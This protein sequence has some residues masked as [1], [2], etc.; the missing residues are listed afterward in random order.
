[1]P[2]KKPVSRPRFMVLLLV[3]GTLAVYLPAARHEFT[4]YDDSVYVS[5]NPVV[6]SGLTWT[7]IKWAFTTWHGANWH[8]LTWLSHMIDCQ[9]FG[10]NA[11]MHHEINVLFHTANVVLLFHLLR[12]W[13]RALWPSAVAAALFAWHPL[14]V[15]SVAWISERKDVLSTFFALLSLLAYTRFADEFKVQGP[16]S[17]L[18]YALAL[19]MFALGLMAKPTVVTL[20]FV[21]LLLDYWPLQR[22]EDRRFGSGVPGLVLEKIPFFALSGGSCVITFLA[23]HHGGAVATL[24]KVPLHYRLENVPVAYLG[25]LQ[26]LFWPSALAIPYPMLYLPMLRVAAA[27]AVLIL[28][29]MAFWWMRKRGPYWMVGW[30]WF[31]GTLVPVIGLLQVGSAAMADR[32]TYFPSI[33][34]FLALALG[35][36]AGVKGLHWPR[37]VVGWVAGAALA[38]CL[39]LTSFQLSYWENDISLFSHAVAVTKDNGVAHVNLGYALEKEGRKTE[40]TVEYLFAIKLE[41][42]MVEPHNDL[43]HLLDETGHPTEAMAEYREA[44]RIKPGY[45]ASHNNYGTLLVELGRFDEAMNHYDTAARLDPTDWHAPYL[46]GQALL[47]QG[48]DPEAIPYFRRALQIDPNNLHVLTY[49]AQVLASDENPKIRN[50]NAALAMAAKANELTGGVQPA[51]L[52]AMAM[53]YAEIGQF[54]EARKTAAYAVKLATA[55]KMTNDMVLIRERLQL[56]Q[57]QQPYRQSFVYTNA[58]KLRGKLTLP[59]LR[60]D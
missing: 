52:D 55:Y 49:L 17:K 29:S 23:Q 56:Y 31:L 26:K 7:A 45:I 12:R 37:Q 16:S 41:P 6:Q 44:L 50:G 13:T 14:H 39:I 48:R 10:L 2:Y 32:Y 21:M 19:L 28:V 57:N 42:E 40:A 25:Y 54:E 60:T 35:V 27:A 51:M 47:K 8:P 38:A 18:F 20:P 15:E 3:L 46:I 34:I 53:A 36:D 4:C 5:E 1:M 43:A 11:G 30:L 33:G 22:L 24:D 9:F 59:R 58:T